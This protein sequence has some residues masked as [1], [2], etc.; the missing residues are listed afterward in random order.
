ME[1]H[2]REAGQA[3]LNP[4][5][6]AKFENQHLRDLDLS[7]RRLVQLAAIG[8]VFERCRFE[9]MRVDAASLGA[10]VAISQFIDCSFDGSNIRMGGGFN[11]FVRCSFCNVQLR[12]WDGQYLEMIDC[13]IT[14]QIHSSQFWGSP[15]SLSA[16]NRLASYTRWREKQE[17]DPPTEEINALYLREK[18]EFHGNDFSDAELVNVSF[19]AGIDLS[20][21]RLPSGDDY[22]YLPAAAEAIDRALNLLPRHTTDENLR[23][24][25]DRFLR[26]TLMREINKGQRQLL[27]RAKN[28]ARKGAIPPAV[29]AAV[30][31]L[32]QTRN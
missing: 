31:L 25:I 17:M 26:G 5:E 21:Q 20:R 11:R 30:D 12:D 2:A 1:I 27:I 6:H 3:T 13:V 19:R 7:G 14:G 15:D 10:G 23:T 9:R 16:R 8:S 28:F 32:R 4:G 22:L 24:G 29:S 18:N